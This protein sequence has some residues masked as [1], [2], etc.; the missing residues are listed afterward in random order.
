MG[1]SDIIRTIL[2]APIAA[3]ISLGGFIGVSEF[4]DIIDPHK[5]VKEGYVIPSKLEIERQ[6][7]DRDGKNEVI[8]KYEGKNYLLLLDSRGIPKV[9]PYEHKIVPTE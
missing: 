6:D 4:L 2:L 9:Q 1:L 8:M 7:L 3:G 5:E